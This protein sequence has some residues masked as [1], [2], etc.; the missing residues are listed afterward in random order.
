MDHLRI[1]PFP[2]CTRRGLSVVRQGRACG[3]RTHI[4][5][6]V[7]SVRFSSTP[8]G[9]S[10]HCESRIATDL[11]TKKALRAKATEGGTCY[12]TGTWLGAADF[13][14]T[15]FQAIGIKYVKDFQWALATAQT[16]TL[17][18]D[19][20]AAEAWRYRDVHKTCRRKSRFFALTTRKEESPSQF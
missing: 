9:I 2:A 15:H 4:D 12:D 11:R 17:R 1:D 8:T 6:P 18:V 20:P 10:A 5:H 19:A 14:D 3:E 7:G 16:L 13:L